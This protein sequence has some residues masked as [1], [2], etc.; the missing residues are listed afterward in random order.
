LPSAEGYECDPPTNFTAGQDRPSVPTFLVWT[1]GSDVNVEFDLDSLPIGSVTGSSIGPKFKIKSKDAAT[2]IHDFTFAHWAD[3]T[4]ISLK[5]HFEIQND[6]YDHWTPDYIAKRLDGSSVVVEFTTNRSDNEASM[7]QSYNS[8]VGKYEVALRNRSQRGLQFF[9]VVVSDSQVITNLPLN[10]SEVDELCFRE[11]VSKAVFSELISKLIVP[12]HLDEDDDKRSREVKATFQSIQFDW[13]TTETKFHPFSERMFSAFQSLSPDSEYLGSIIK[14]SLKEAQKNLDEDHLL[15]KSMTDSE[16]QLRNSELCLSEIEEFRTHFNDQASRSAYDHKS[17]IPIPGIIPKVSGDTTSLTGLQDLPPMTASKDATARAWRSSISQVL[18][19]DVERV[20]EDVDKERSIAL[21]NLS[22]TELAEIKSLRQKFHRCSPDLDKTDQ[23]ELALQGV[24]AKQFRGHPRLEEKRKASKRTFPLFTDVRDIDSFI[25]KESDEFSEELKQEVP[26]ALFESVKSA[27]ESQSL[28][29]IN[30]QDNHWFKATSWFISL[31]IGIW[32]FLVTCIGVELSIALK[33]HCGRGKFI[34]KKIRFFDIFLLIKPTNSGSHVFF[35]LAFPESAILGK[36]HSSAVFKALNYEDGWYWTEFHS[37]KMSKLTN[38]V[39]T[40]SMGFNLFWFWRDFFEV[41]FWEGSEKTKL[42]GIKKANKMFKFCLLMLAEDK[43]KSEEIAT[44]SRYVLMEGFVSPPCLP[45]PSKMISKIPEFART[46]LQVWLINKLLLAMVRV[47]RQPFKISVSAKGTTW[48]SMFNWITGDKIGT[49]QKLISLFY[50]GYIKNK[51]ESPEKNATAGMYKKILEYEQKHPGRYEFLGLGDPSPDDV[52]FHEYSVSFLK[53]LSI[54]AKHL[55][56]RDWGEN[57][58]DSIHRDIIGEISRLDLERVSTLKASS[59]FNEEWYFRRTDKTYHRSKVLE[60]AAA[61]INPATSH[62]HHILKCCLEKVESRGAMHICLFKKPQHGGLREIYVLGFEERIIQLVIETIAR[63]I[64]KKFKSETLTN[65]K[66]KLIIPETHGHRAS[67]VCGLQH[68]TIG[69]SDDAAKW[70]QCHHVTKFALM[71][72]EFTHPSLHPFIVRGCSLF[73]KKRIMIDPHFL[74]IIDSHTD[75]KT[76]D[77]FVEGI[78]KAYHGNIEVPWMSSGTGYLE[79]ETGMMQGILHY[80][81]SLFHTLLQEWLRSFSKKLFYPKVIWG[82]QCDV[83]IDVLQSSDDSGLLISIP[84]ADPARLSKFRYLVALLFKFKAN[85]GKYLA[86]YTSVKS[87]SNTLGVLEFNSE[88]FFHINHNRP[89][90]RWIA[91]C[92]LISEQE[93][94]AARQEEIYNNLTAV[95]EG[96]ASFSL[97]AFCQYGQMLLHYTLLGLTTSPLFL[98]YIKMVSILCDPSLGF[99]LMDHPFGA[100]LAGFKY[101]LW[102]TVQNSALGCRYN[103]LLNRIATGINGSLKKT[104]DTTSSGTFVQST[105]IRFGDRKK[106]LRL[107]DKLNLPDNWLEL[108]DLYPEI[109]YRRPLDGEEVKLKLAEKIHSPGVSNSLSKGNCIIRIISSS[110]YILS[111]ATLTD[112]L[113]W[114]QEDEADAKGKFSLLKKV[115][116]QTFACGNDNLSLNQLTL[117]FPLHGE[118]DRLRSHFL[119]YLSITGKHIKKTKVITQ[120]RVSILESE[121]FMRVKPEDLISDKWFGLNRSRLTPRMFKQEWESLKTTFPWIRDTPEET[122]ELSPFEHHVQLRN[123]FSRLDLKGRDIRIIGAPIKKTSGVSNVSTAIRDNFFPKFL[124][125]FSAD[126]EGLDRAEAAGVLKH[127]L[128]LCLTGPYTDEAK[129]NMVIDFLSK[130]DKIVLRPNHGKTRSNVLSLLQDFL[131]PHGPETILNRIELANC[132]VIGGFTSPQKAT[133][134]DGKVTYSGEGTW[135][136]VV[137]GFQIQITIGS[138]AVQGL[139]QIKSVTVNN[140]RAISMIPAFCKNWSEEMHVFNSKNF[141][142][143]KSSSASF[144]LLNF[145]LSTAR[146][147]EGAPVYIVTDKIYHPI[148]WQIDNLELKVRRQTIN[149]T[150]YLEKTSRKWKPRQLNI[151]SYTIRDTDVSELAAAKMMTHSSEFCIHRREP[152]TSWICMRSLPIPVVDRLIDYLQ[153]EKRISAGIDNELLKRCFADVAES[154]LRKR[155]VFLSEFSKQVKS[156]LENKDFDFLDIFA[157]AGLECNMEDVLNWIPESG[158]EFQ[159]DPEDYFDE[160]NLTPFG[161]FTV[162]QEQESKYYHHKLLDAVIEDL[163]QKLSIEGIRSLLCNCVA[164][165]KFKEE[166]SRFLFLAGKDPT[167]VK[168]VS[169]DFNV[170]DMGLDVEDD[171]FG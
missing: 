6:S 143:K 93:S 86:I 8:K 114:L 28:H 91:A 49:T 83:L 1:D 61:Y 130:S 151:L 16:R 107:V 146:R 156:L 69:S 119:G 118:Y 157:E 71:L 92:D 9:V 47:S 97:V 73:M 79:T 161:M 38:V 154:A 21:E 33:Q 141:A 142:A 81:S 70:N 108:L 64:C 158:S 103:D 11:I 101:N 90:F 147:P 67:K 152:S 37:Y 110:V 80:T 160:I 150:Y 169:A 58:L 127:C 82:E 45:K 123:F 62:V 14:D 25:D 117:L 111:R 167:E 96:G 88:F 128:F 89:L 17:T 27:A 15:S 170:E 116:D 87:T 2:F 54:H 113:A 78:H 24:E 129:Y 18:T 139:T 5:S 4:D 22:E 171:M 23:V 59:N 95:L 30:M 44:L 126:S 115:F 148:Q 31:P 155:G 162:Q 52:R 135:R 109:L 20:V 40:M 65:P 10:Q 137:D 46:K 50:L 106:W 120:T 26:A 100:G 66:Q 112:G 132:G 12:E 74:D 133:E 85:I 3:S 57:V 104:L 19:G 77:P 42:E 35:S 164:P 149:L 60:K 102:I 76:G 32:L 53:H 165:L 41:P 84:S 163:I 98:E 140:E 153:S 51:E 144:Y 72:C 55:L 125:D 29:G 134:V 145:K 168:W 159:V 105:I 34:M 68:E 136:G 56:R 7:Q 75:L 122:L 13:T 63:Q 94:L 131:G 48:T 43:A 124:L 121:R 99:F 36:L 39:R 166:C 138:D